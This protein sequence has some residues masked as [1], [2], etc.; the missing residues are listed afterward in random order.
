LLYKN[1]KLRR[2]FGPKGRKKKVSG[3][4]S[5]MRRMQTVFLASYYDDRIKEDSAP[6]NT[7]VNNGGAIPPLSHKS[8]RC[9]A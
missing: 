5:I 1:K 3:E 4:N 2:T 8:S 6:P 9:S 7:E